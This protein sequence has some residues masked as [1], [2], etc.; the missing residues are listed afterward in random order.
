M[1]EGIWSFRCGLKLTCQ[2]GMEQV[3]DDWVFGGE[4]ACVEAV[5]GPLLYTVQD[6]RPDTTL[7]PLPPGL[8]VLVAVLV[9]NRRYNHVILYE[10]EPI[11]KYFLLSIWLI[12]VVLWLKSPCQNSVTHNTYIHCTCL[13]W[14][15][16][17]R[18]ERTRA[19]TKMATPPTKLPATPPARLP[20]STFVDYSSAY[21]S[22]QFGLSCG[23]FFLF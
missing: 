15:R 20:S 4:E 2:N 12:R 3:V 1:K 13:K 22:N 23:N 8:K 16:A 6:A 14:T 11:S 7:R 17:W 10:I 5:L 19:D 9:M 21:M 18:A